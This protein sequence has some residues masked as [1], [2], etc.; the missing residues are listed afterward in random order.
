M[1]KELRDFFLD[2]LGIIDPF[3]D[4]ITHF[5][6]KRGNDCINFTTLSSD[7]SLVISGTTKK[8]IKKFEHI[9]GLGS[10]Q[11]LKAIVDSD[12]MKK[13]NDESMIL[14]YTESRT[15][16]KTILTSIEFKGENRFTA[17]YQATDPFVAQLNKVKSIGNLEWPVAFAVDADFKKA[18]DEIR[19]INSQ[20][21]KTGSDR[22]DIFE[23]SYNNDIITGIFGGRGN[24]TSITLSEFVESNSDKN[25]K[26]LFQISKFKSVLNLL[27][28]G[29]SIAYLCDK[30]IKVDISTNQAN[31]Q[32]VMT[33]KK[34]IE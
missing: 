23:I 29:D 6:L 24:R 34:I 21:S 13:C 32:F 26:A 33:A 14:N 7:N 1:S 22:D 19:R 20:A 18:F 10:L 4:T 3:K 16:N 25:M 2:S 9:A 5:L 28:K 30:A 27:D 15:G 31:Y 12:L 17:F 11:Y 8:E